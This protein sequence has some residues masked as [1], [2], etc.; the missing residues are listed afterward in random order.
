MKF[1]DIWQGDPS[2]SEDIFAGIYAFTNGVPRRINTLM[3]RLLLHG[4]LEEIHEIDRDGL[5]AVTNDIIEEQGD[6]ADSAPMELPTLETS[7]GIAPSGR[8]SVHPG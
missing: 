7:P 8:S 5:D 4:Y 1:C 2:F 6:P 3:D